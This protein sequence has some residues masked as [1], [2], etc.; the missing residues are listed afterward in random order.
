MA[1]LLSNSLSTRAV[2]RPARAVQAQ[3]S[4]RQEAVKCGPWTPTPRYAWLTWQMLLC[5]PVITGCKAG[6][7]GNYLTW[8]A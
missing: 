6:V 2:A 3:A 8:P 4:L 1:M 7:P 5:A